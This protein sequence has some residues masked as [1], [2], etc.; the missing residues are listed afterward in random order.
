MVRIRYFEAAVTILIHRMVVRTTIGPLSIKHIINTLVRG[1][2]G[3][4]NLK[5]MLFEKIVCWLC[6]FLIRYRKQIHHAV[7]MLT[8]FR[9]RLKMSEFYLYRSKDTWPAADRRLLEQP[10][11][12]DL[13]SCSRWCKDSHIKTIVKVS[14]LLELLISTTIRMDRRSTHHSVQQGQYYD[15]GLSTVRK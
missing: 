8:S 15:P 10:F 9:K 12:A 6:V 1:V 13:N 5:Q 4:P 3:V 14:R 11:S 7:W 2:V